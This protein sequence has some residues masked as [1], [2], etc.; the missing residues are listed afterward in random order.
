MR[1]M[2]VLL[3]FFVFVSSFI[4]SHYSTCSELHPNGM[5][6]RHIKC[7]QN[8]FVINCI[9]C[10]NVKNFSSDWHV[11]GLFSI[12]CHVVKLPKCTPFTL[13]LKFKTNPSTNSMNN[14]EF[15]LKQQSIAHTMYWRYIVIAISEEK[16]WGTLRRHC[17]QIV[18]V[19]PSISSMI[20]LS[21]QQSHVWSVNWVFRIYLFFCSTLASLFAYY[22]HWIHQSFYPFTHNPCWLSLD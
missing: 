15:E 9:V 12:K 17:V 21:V 18:I 10:R 4:R 6:R 3:F 20:V 13:G 14:V 8:Y 19:H 5:H 22:L 1:S 7:K 2:F 16:L 11:Y